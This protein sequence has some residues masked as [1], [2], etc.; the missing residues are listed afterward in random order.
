MKTIDWN[1]AFRNAR[2]IRDVAVAHHSDIFTPDL[3]PLD[4]M[5][6]DRFGG[7][8]LFEICIAIYCADCDREQ[9]SGLFASAVDASHSRDRLEDFI[10]EM[11][12]CAQTDFKRIGFFHG[13]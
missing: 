2:L 11:R 7:V 8:S 6:I 3:M 13:T 4:L 12:S 9:I 5:P 10:L 1:E